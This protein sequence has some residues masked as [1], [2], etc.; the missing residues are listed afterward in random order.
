MAKN[1]VEKPD[2]RVNLKGV[3]VYHTIVARIYLAIATFSHDRNEQVL[4]V[5]Y[6]PKD[7][8]QK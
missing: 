2:M 7:L 5:L 6:T 8:K 3:L 4:H 1:R